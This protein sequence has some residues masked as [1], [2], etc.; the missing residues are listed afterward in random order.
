LTDAPKRNEAPAAETT[1]ASND[2]AGIASE[3]D[4]ANVAQAEPN[5]NFPKT[6]IEFLRAFHDGRKPCLV[7]IS[8]D[9]KR[10]AARTP[11]EASKCAAWIDD[12]NGSENLYHHVNATRAGLHAK[13]KKE[14]ITAA[15]WLH[16]D[17]DARV[18]EPLESELER[19][20]A[21]LKQEA[22]AQLSIPPATCV[23]FS[24]GGYQAFW[25]LARAL[26]PEHFAQVEAVNK[27][28]SYL[29]GGDA[30]Q[31]INRIMR[32]P[33]TWNVPDAKKRA[34]GREKAMARV[35]WFNG[36]LSYTLDDFPQPPRE[37]DPT[38]PAPVAAGKML[39][40][41]ELPERLQVIAREGLHPDEPAK[42]SRSEWLFDFCCNAVRAGANDDAIFAIITDS[43]LK[44]SESVL[45]KKRNA[46]RYARNQIKKAREAAAKSEEPTLWE[47][48]RTF[49]DG[50]NLVRANGDWFA[51][52]GPRW[53]DEHP[54]LVLRDVY[55]FVASSGMAPG[56]KIINPL[57]QAITAR[58]AER[59]AAFPAWRGVPVARHVLSCANGLVD[60]ETGALHPHTPDFFNLNATDYDYDP[61]AGEPIEWFRFLNS[62]WADDPECI[63]VL[64]RMFGYLLT[65][66]TSMQKIFQLIGPPSGGKGTIGDTLA[67]VLGRENICSPSLQNIHESFALAPAIG[68]LVMLLSE[69]RLEGSRKAA[70]TDV[71]LRISGEDHF[72]V[73]RKNRDHWE[74][75][76]PARGVLLTNEPLEL[77]DDTGALLRRLIVLRM[78]HSFRGKEDINLRQK[79]RAERA[80]ILKW[81]IEGWRLLRAEGGV[82]QQ[83]ASGAAVVAATKAA[84]SPLTLFLSEECEIAVDGD[85]AKEAF[86][87]RYRQWC[88]QNGSHPLS[89]NRLT[90]KLEANYPIRAVDGAWINKKR[91]ERGPK[92]YV[93]VRLLKTQMTTPHPR[94]DDQ[95]PIPF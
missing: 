17:I 11:A 58:A 23:V 91:G 27:Q 48:A 9:K 45:E 33:G 54:D 75:V 67:G 34:K 55:E 41:A 3:Q 26:G 39:A 12:R 16:V 72:S 43:T 88:A 28:L 65:P 77:S 18:G 53:R 22:L 25:R 24:G 20:R 35:H 85:V 60:L 83:P 8:P 47:L 6:A 50:R 29:L 5:D 32:L 84:A 87:M 19:I 42:P 93:G 86:Y 94:P 79:L 1:E 37:A 38:P 40:L 82:I 95:H 66:D 68:K 51:W 76:L 61:H 74:G 30:T 10:I 57:L 89:L 31:D 52:D 36:A 4:S 62:I 2:V 69:A 7:A 80:A 59:V 13:A 70:I 21:L 14:D 64:Q 78:T 56:P 49:V 46:T 90:F 63:A 81:A 92:R 73:N 71:L 44:I 15:H